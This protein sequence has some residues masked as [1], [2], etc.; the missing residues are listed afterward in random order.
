[1][2]VLVPSVDLEQLRRQ[3]KD[4]LRA[5]K[6]GDATA[7]TRIGAVSD[8]LIL[9]TA[10]LALAREFGFESWAKLKLEVERRQILDALDATGLRGLLVAHPELAVQKMQGWRDHPRNPRGLT[11]LGYL[12]AMPFDTVRKVWR[13]IAGTGPLAR[14]LLWAGAPVDGAPGDPETPL[15][16]AASYGNTEV[17]KVLVEA[18]A[19]LTATASP[20]AGGVPNGTALRHAVVFGMTEVVEVLLAAGA[21]DLVHSAATGSVA[22]MLTAATSEADR[23]AALRIAAEHGQLEVI[24][25]LLAAGTPI[26]GVDRDGSTALHAAAYHG[27]GNGV[28][29]LLD[30]GADPTRRDTRFDS[31]PLGWSHAG[32]RDEVGPEDGHDEVEGMLAPLTPEDP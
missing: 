8:R 2:S 27:Q 30:R 15:M 25:D 1:M 10:Q 29:H 4:L 23:V 6:R 28:R 16:T 7:L 21:S 5:A 26:D 12:A 32:R 9:A 17:A 31:P 14:E 24:D 3:A 20:Q 22:G 18:G 13:I 19:S 11:P